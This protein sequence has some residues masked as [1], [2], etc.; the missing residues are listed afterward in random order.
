[1]VNQN[2]QPLDEPNSVQSSAATVQQIIVQ[3]EETIRAG[4]NSNGGQ[5]NDGK[6]H[7]TEHFNGSIKELH[8]DTTNVKTNGLLYAWNKVDRE[9]AP[10][11]DTQ[12]GHHI[13]G[14]IKESRNVIKKGSQRKVTKFAAS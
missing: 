8:W 5:R 14:Q 6:N 1:V 4:C 7:H 12:T 3:T 13:E 2:V 9:N 11:E 10:N